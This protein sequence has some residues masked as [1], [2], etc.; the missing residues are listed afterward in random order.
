MRITDRMS[1]LERSMGLDTTLDPIANLLLHL[2]LLHPDH[3]RLL[4]ELELAERRNLPPADPLLRLAA[5]VAGDALRL[6]EL[7][8]YESEAGEL[9]CQFN[10]ALLDLLR[11]RAAAAVENETKGESK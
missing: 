4:A 3:A 5:Q 1:R 9:L 10:E 11:L 6:R 8:L 7:G 2:L